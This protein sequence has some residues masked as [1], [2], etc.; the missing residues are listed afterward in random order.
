MVKRSDGVCEA[1]VR[2]ASTSTSHIGAP[3]PSIEMKLVPAERGIIKM[4][5]NMYSVGTAI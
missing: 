4:I 3:P 5:A 2:A 1:V